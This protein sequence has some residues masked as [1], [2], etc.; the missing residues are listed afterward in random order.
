MD[1]KLPYG[2]RNDL[3]VTIDSVESGLKCDCICPYCKTILIARKGSIKEHHFAH[4][5]GADCEKAIETVTHKISKEFIKGAKYFVTPP[6][7]FPYTKIPIIDE[8]KVPID[9]VSLESKV[10][11]IV[12]DIIIESGGKILLVEIR[13]THG[14]DFEKERKI[15][16]LKLPA[17]EILASHLIKKLYS[18]NKYFLDDAEYKRFLIDE[19]TGKRWLNN[20]RSDRKILRIR[21]ELKNY[22]DEKK[23]NFLKFSFKNNHPYFYDAKDHMY[24]VESCPINKRTWKGGKRKG[25]SY[26]DFY[27][28]CTRC[29]FNADIGQQNHVPNSIHCLGNIID[30]NRLIKGLVHV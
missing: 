24:Y 17:I 20:P 26:A 3:L 10:G 22:S 1:L 19:Y 4:Y 27:E 9:N 30:Y 15:V 25:S 7:Y 5:K 6:I 13:V 16:D 28:D 23:I 8:A 2:L 18:Q 21:D 14:V 11:S 29:K 12:P